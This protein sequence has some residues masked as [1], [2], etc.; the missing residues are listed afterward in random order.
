M[1][2]LILG[3]TSESSAL[4]RALAGRTDVAPILSLA[5]R[6]ARPADV[7][8]PVRIGGFGGVE[9]LA[10]FLETDGIAAVVDATHPFASRMSAHA[11]AACAQRAVP[12]ARLTRPPWVPEPGDD[13][14]RVADLDAAAAALGAAPRRV[15]LTSGRLGLASFKRAPQHHYLLRSI[16]PPSR[17]DQPPLCG[18]V[19]AR[20]PFALAEEDALMREHRIDVLVSKNSGGAGTAKFAAAR[21]LAIPVIMVER[22]VEDRATDCFDDLAALLGWIEAQRGAPALRGVSIQRTPVA[23]ST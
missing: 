12:L 3:G 6:T 5:G 18:I 23:P 15:F 19:L 16:D 21:N 13:W 1:R 11:L 8:V 22:P 7:P 17:E 20:P 14:R 9:G 2:L 10:A 4:A